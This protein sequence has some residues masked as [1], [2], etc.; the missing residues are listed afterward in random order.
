MFAGTEWGI[1]VPPTKDQEK[2]DQLNRVPEIKK[3]ML[4]YIKKPT[5]PPMTL[6]QLA[7]KLGVAVRFLTYHCS[8]LSNEVK[9]IR[10]SYLAKQTAEEARSIK[11][12][13]SEVLDNPPER[14]TKPVLRRILEKENGFSR[15]EVNKQLKHM[16]FPRITKT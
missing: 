8:E 2:N 11:F 1:N 5:N 14:L 13:I 6:T 10:N 4:S 15:R 7:E 12:K 9:A 3:Q 16:R